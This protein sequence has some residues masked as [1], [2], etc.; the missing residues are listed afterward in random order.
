[1]NRRKTLKM[2]GAGFLSGFVPAPLA[3]AGTR[4]LRGYVRTNWSRD[5]LTYGSYSYVPKGVR[6]RDR[7]ALEKPIS[8]RVFF[9]GEAVFAKYNSTVHAAYGSGRH[10]AGMVHKAGAAR[11]AIIGAG[12]SGLAAAQRLAGAGLDVMVFEARSRIGGRIWTDNRLGQPLDLGASW[13]HGVRGNPITELA[14]QAG[15]KRIATDESYVTRGG[16]GRR[17]DDA[18]YPDWL[19][20]V[21]MTQQNAGADAGQLNMKV[22]NNE[23][24][25]GGADV[26]FSNGYAGILGSL[27]GA[28]AVHL[29][30]AVRA[31]SYTDQGVTLRFKNR[32]DA[33]FDAVIV[34][35][36]LGV[37][38]R[39][40]VQFTPALP[41][42]K[43][44]AIQRLG[45]GV[46]DKV[47]LKFDRPFWEV[48]A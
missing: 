11:V 4:P 9:A 10:T 39:G 41:T 21:V 8:D 15:L 47:Y 6:L 45:M 40:T 28:Y 12:M 36:P 13:I 7:K 20:D 48:R 25:Y 5:P 22:Y 38:K 18:Q 43:R 37:L 3:Y 35:V 1:M 26:V 27:K 17:I 46:L 16:D 14:D 44:K 33:A 29:S 42:A 31:V 19:E 24:G 34:T 23:D 2:F 30:T 32:A